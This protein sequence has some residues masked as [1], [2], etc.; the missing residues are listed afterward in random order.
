L[1]YHVVSGKFLANQLTNGEL[2]PSLLQLQ[3]LN[4]GY[5]QLKVTINGTTGNLAI[6]AS[7]KFSISESF[8]VFFFSLD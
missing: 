7:T 5:Q 1:S 6:R 2:V 3:S 4:G 8:L